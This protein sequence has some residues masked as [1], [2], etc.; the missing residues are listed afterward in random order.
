[1][2]IHP[3]DVLLL[4]LVNSL[5]RQI[6]ISSINLCLDQIHVY[7]MFLIYV[8]CFQTFIRIE[9]HVSNKVYVLVIKLEILTMT[10]KE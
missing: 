5:S 1:M 10:L 4:E 2:T 9:F 6:L 3:T 8:L 7:F